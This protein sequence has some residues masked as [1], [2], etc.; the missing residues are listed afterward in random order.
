MN[1]IGGA[2]A[3]AQF[4]KGGNE[5]VH[6][7]L[8]VAA[9]LLVLWFLFH[10]SMAILNFVWIIIAILIVLWLVGLMRGRTAP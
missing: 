3:S 8:V 6:T 7:L 2:V 10:A 5:L 4:E 9:V 1:S